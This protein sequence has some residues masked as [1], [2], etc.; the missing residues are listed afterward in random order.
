[1]QKLKKY[2]LIFFFI[3]VACIYI[4]DVVP[5]I[6]IF[7]DGYKAVDA[8]IEEY[9]TI[10]NE[11][12][13]KINTSQYCEE[14]DMFVSAD[15][16]LY[17]IYFVNSQQKIA[18][19]RVK[20]QITLP[21]VNTKSNQFSKI[22]TQNK[23]ICLYHTHNDESYV[24]GDGYDSVYGKGGIMD[25][26]AQLKDELNKLNITV[27]VSDNL[28][29]PHDYNAYS[30]SQPTAKNLIDK[31]SPDAIF[32]VHRDGVARNQYITTVDNQQM[33]KIRMVIGKS[34]PNYSYNLDFALAIKAYADE[35]YS[36]LIKDIYMGSGH[37]NQALSKTA[38]LFEMGTYLI[39]KDYVVSSL[40][41]LAD[42]IDKVMYEPVVVAPD[43]TK[44]YNEVIEDLKN[45]QQLNS[46]QPSIEGEINVED[47]I[48]QP[49][50]SN[51][52]FE[53]L[54]IFI[55]VFILISSLFLL[56]ML[57]KKFKK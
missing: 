35:N 13:Q 40:P 57:V 38:I 39:E 37:Y 10:Y 18:Y 54:T 23:V 26:G 46:T 25:I 3:A 34:N 48:T 31:Y 1:M 6:Q 52:F 29:L 55:T 36:G 53:L 21:K 47:V 24:L 56:C 41:K 15:N 4:L 12:G 42:T 7:E 51:A 2:S 27:Y 30:R 5:I 8:I 17:E 20:T 28:H 43:E 19:A 11:N 22:A 45:T 33:S 16:V 14:G 50:K 9:Y 32:D 49:E 44:T